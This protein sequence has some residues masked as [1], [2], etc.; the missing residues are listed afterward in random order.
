MRGVGAGPVWAT[1]TTP[2]HWRRRSPDVLRI[3]LEAWRIA[4]G[5]VHGRSAVV[6]VFPNVR[7]RAAAGPIDPERRHYARCQ[8]R[9]RHKERHGDETP[10]LQHHQ[11]PTARPTPAPIPQP[12]PETGSTTL[13]P[14]LPHKPTGS[15][16]TLLAGMKREHSSLFVLSQGPSLHAEIS[17]PKSHDMLVNMDC[18]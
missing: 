18:A 12:S 11:R 17:P 9:K 1:A 6:R 10:S 16:A 15:S 13:R 4:L 3:S 2:N 8:R 14:E 5:R 7:G